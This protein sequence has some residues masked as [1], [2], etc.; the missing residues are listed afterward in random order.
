[1]AETKEYPQPLWDLIK[2]LG[3][4]PGV[5]RIYGY[6]P[7]F[8]GDLRAKDIFL[9]ILAENEDYSRGIKGTWYWET[10]LKVEGRKVYI[11]SESDDPA[12]YEMSE[13]LAVL[14]WTKKM[15]AT[16]T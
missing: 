16:P 10:S 12:L 13:P 7:F 2:Q 6:G 5:V 3:K 15:S 1:M 11:R 4:E 8:S 9:M 14:L